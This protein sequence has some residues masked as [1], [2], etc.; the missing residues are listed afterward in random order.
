MVEIK[1]TEFIKFIIGKMFTPNTD[2]I[3]KSQNKKPP[4]I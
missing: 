1:A 2:H 3:I 4:W